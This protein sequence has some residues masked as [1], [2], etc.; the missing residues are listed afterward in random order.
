MVAVI[1]I[2]ATPPNSSVAEAG[3]FQ[4]ASVALGMAAFIA[5]LFTIKLVTAPY[6][7]RDAYWRELVALT[8]EAADTDPDAPKLPSP[9]LYITYHKHEF[10][11]A[12]EGE[13]T[14]LSVN[15]G[16]PILS[17]EAAY[18]PTGPMRIEVVELCIVGKRISS[19]NGEVQEPN[20]HRWFVPSNAFNVLGISPGEHDAELFAFANGRW[21]RSH[22]FTVLFPAVTS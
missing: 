5:I 21:W 20:D 9:E 13:Y 6:R 11:V 10:G 1:A 15:N 19:L 12:G 8:E 16:I 3:V 7:Q 14:G 17:V 2:A 4:V 18:R 22:P